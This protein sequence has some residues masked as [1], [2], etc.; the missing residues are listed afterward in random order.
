[1]SARFPSGDAAIGLG[2]RAFDIEQ[3]E[4]QCVKIT[5]VD[6]RPEIAGGLDRGMKAQFLRSGEN[7]LG[8]GGLNHWFPAGDGEAA[9]ERFQR[10]PESAEPI[11]DLLRRN[12]GA[13]LQVPSIGIVTVAAP[14]KA[15][16]NE[17]NNPKTRAVITEEVSYECA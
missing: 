2:V 7:A 3:H 6:A 11:K 14:K 4:I 10:I 17:E 12:I 8:K 1:M 16:R 5:V 9:T 13:V 15:S